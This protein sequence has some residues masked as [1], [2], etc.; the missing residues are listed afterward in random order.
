M[1]EQNALFEIEVAL[2]FLLQEFQF[3]NGTHGVAFLI[4]LIK[5][6]EANRGV[7]LEQAAARNHPGEAARGE[8]SAAEA[9]EENFVAGIVMF[10]E[11]AITRA[12]VFGEP[13]A[14]QP[15]GQAIEPVGADAFVVELF[16]RHAIGASIGEHEVEPPDI[17]VGFGNIPGPIEEERE[18]FAREDPT[19]LRFHVLS[20][21]A[22]VGISAIPVF[23]C[24]TCRRTDSRI[25]LIVAA[26]VRRIETPATSEWGNELD[27]GAAAQRKNPKGIQSFSPGLERSDY[28]G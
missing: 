5:L 9:K 13:E 28:P 17:G 23:W 6:A 24:D 2:P 4:A 7:R 14:K 19:W 21:S 3:V 26:G 12:D 18:A 22:G 27:L 25:H 15:A 11:P 10:H 20:C 16:L 8:R 1:L